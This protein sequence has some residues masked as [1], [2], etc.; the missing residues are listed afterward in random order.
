MLQGTKE[1]VVGGGYVQ[2]IRR[3]GEQLPSQLD[4][5]LACHFCRVGSCVIVKHVDFVELW[6]FEIESGLESFQLEAVEV[7]SDY[8]IIWEE[9]VVDYAANILPN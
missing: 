7:G 5:L 9:L 2:G 8:S 6:T 3:M 4:Q 1:M